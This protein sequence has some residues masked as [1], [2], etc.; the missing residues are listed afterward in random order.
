[1]AMHAHL[2]VLLLALAL[3][4]PLAHGQDTAGWSLDAVLDS[5][6]APANGLPVLAVTPGGAAE[7]MGI[8][9]GD[10]ILSINGRALASVAS[11]SRALDDALQAGNGRAD[12]VLLRDGQRMRLQGALARAPAVPARG[13]GY[14][15]D[16]DQT[17][18]ATEGIYNGEVTQVDGRSTPLTGSPRL[19]M[20]AGPHVLVVSEFIPAQWFTSSQNRARRL[21]KKQMQAKAYKAIVVDVAPNTRYSIGTRLLRDNLDLDSIRDNAY[22]E[23]VVYSTRVEGCR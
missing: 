17:P 11:P 20:S 9:T 19:R 5:R 1:M 8:A 21:M 18:R 16:S 6:S 4:A 15:S 10:R 3:S 7:R 14:V 2:R 22:W 13:C 12:V 23:P